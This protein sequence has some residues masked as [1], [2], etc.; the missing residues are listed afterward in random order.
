MFTELQV[1]APKGLA[2]RVNRIK[3][4]EA[5]YIILCRSMQVYHLYTVSICRSQEG[6]LRVGGSRRPRPNYREPGRFK[7]AGWL[8]VWGV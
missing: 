8:S 7:D 1:N 5:V 4:S 2:R 6:F 3:E